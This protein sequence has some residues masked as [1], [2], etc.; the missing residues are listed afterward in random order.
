MMESLEWWYKIYLNLSDTGEEIH[1]KSLR[2]K[3]APPLRFKYYGPWKYL[4]Q[5]KCRP[6]GHFKI[7]SNS[8]SMAPESIYIKKSVALLVISL[9]RKGGVRGP[10]N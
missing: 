7:P 10:P 6:I 9:W 1:M 2:Q 4:N 8:N 5:E 3:K